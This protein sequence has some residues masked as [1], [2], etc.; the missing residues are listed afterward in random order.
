MPIDTP[1]QKAPR[2]AW[3]MVAL[4]FVYMVLNFADKI[5]VGLAG[6][7]IMTDLNLSP[8]DFGLLGSSFFFLFSIS[9]IVF[10]FIIN[11]VPTRWVLPGLALVWALSQ[12]PML[13]TVSFATLLVCRVILGA[14]EGPAFTVAVHSV[15][16]WFPDHQRTLGSVALDRLV[17]QRRLRFAG[18]LGRD[19]GGGS[20]R[21]H[22]GAVAEHR[23]DHGDV[24]QMA[25]AGPWIVGDQHVAGHECLRRK[26]GKQGLHGRHQLRQRGPDREGGE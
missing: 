2:P 23:R 11:R 4:L 17:E 1:P 6:V 24:E 25:G 12:F 9:A 14:G 5:V 7:P 21:R 10:G 16:K 20:N 18:H 13:G 15:F 26:F 8:T 3:G 22:Q 19:P